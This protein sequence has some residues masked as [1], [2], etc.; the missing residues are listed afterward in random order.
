[1]TK[2]EMRREFIKRR[3]HQTQTELDAKSEEICRKLF[4]LELMQQ[5][6]DVLLYSSYSSEV[7]TEPIFNT[8]RRMRKRAYF[9][10]VEDSELVYYRVDDLAELQVGYHGIME[11]FMLR[12]AAGDWLYTAVAIIPGVCFSREGHRIGY[13]KGYFDR[14]LARYPDIF[15][16]GIG[17]ELQ[18][19]DHIP[20]E[21]QDQ[22]LNAFVSEEEILVFQK[23]K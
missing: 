17:Y 16:I 10:K 7:Q 1:M 2:K 4:S 9:P 23:E 14:F 8:V 5:A 15:T 3:D 11:P 19:T 13:G 6:S 20:A 22:L 21:P 18:L 12:K